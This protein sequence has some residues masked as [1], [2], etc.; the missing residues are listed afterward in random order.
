[1]RKRGRKPLIDL[2]IVFIAIKIRKQDIFDKSS[3]LISITD[4]VWYKIS[5]ELEGKISP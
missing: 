5:R 4:G 1:M 3:N 2:E